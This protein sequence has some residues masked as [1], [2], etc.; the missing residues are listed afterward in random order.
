MN[1]NNVMDM[2]QKARV[3]RPKEEGQPIKSTMINPMNRLMY[4]SSRNVIEPNRGVSYRVLRAVAERAWI[5]NAIIGHQTRN[6]RPFLKPTTEKNERGFRVKPKDINREMNAEERKLA[7]VYQQFFL[8][9]GFADDPEREDDLGLY[10][11]KLVRD[12][13]TLDQVATE[14]QRT[15]ATKVCA[16]WAVDPATILRVAEEGYNGND[17]IRFIQEV[18]LVTT[19]FYTRDDLIFDY[20]NPRTDLDHAGYGYSM[21]EQAVDLVT[22]L[23]NSF[24][25]NMG[26]F[27]EDKLPR[28]MLLLQGDAD[29]EEVEMIEDYLVNIM[30]GGPLSKWHVP[31]IPAG[32]NS[33]GGAGSERKFEW[34]SLQG[35]N[36]DMEFSQW[37]EFL[38]SS[39]AAL[40][41][42]DLEELGIR[43]SKST[44]VI[45]QNTAP[46]LEA[47][48]ARGLGSIL[49][50]IESH[51]QKIMDKLDPR[52]D[53]EFVGYE[54][55]DPVQK[56][57][58]REVQLRTTKCIDDL[59]REDGD[60]PFNQPWSTI[61]LNPYVVQMIQQAQQP[62]G[63]PGQGGEDGQ[64]EAIPP[65]AQGGEANAMG[66]APQG[67]Q[68]G[69]AGKKEEGYEQYRNLVLGGDDGNV[70]PEGQD[71]EDPETGQRR[72]SIFDTV[73]K[74]IGDDTIEIIV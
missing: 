51:M 25:Y 68:P 57:Q 34:V 26:F 46:K 30:S 9:T 28:G 72:T 13:L 44:A 2:L 22:G 67:Q 29:T 49:G 40:F 33:E 74:S 31:I 56:N 71:D 69:S 15:R 63:M 1:E 61:P 20:M 32:K 7:N 43:T 21:V 17:A 10:S 59:R 38:W 4:R 60:E 12:L 62:Q 65:E 36:K 48:K 47:S 19:A 42:V 16:F 23:I 35:S 66:D 6:I 39:V 11:G 64:G 58:T 45:G 73:E 3:V 70:A 50:F 54:K 52:F 53:F 55:E 27:T 8:R 5:I 18:D 24:M 41:G 37:T 14:L